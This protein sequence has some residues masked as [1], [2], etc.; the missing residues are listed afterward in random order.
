[1]FEMS[2]WSLGRTGKSRSGEFKLSLAKASLG[3]LDG[4]DGNVIGTFSENYA[5]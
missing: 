3:G 5:L 2:R 4:Q 1:M